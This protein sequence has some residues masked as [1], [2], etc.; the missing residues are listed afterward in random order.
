MGW[1]F[2]CVDCVGCMCGRAL[3]AGIVVWEPTL[4]AGSSATQSDM[5]VRA[6]LTCTDECRRLST[7][8][9]MCDSDM[10]LCH[11]QHIHARLHKT[12]HIPPKPL[13]AHILRIWIASRNPSSTGFAAYA[14]YHL[15]QLSSPASPYDPY[16]RAPCRE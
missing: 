4:T 14:L 10:C 9:W 12:T 3:C 11:S 2:L 1:V 6:E 7:R 15:S 13:S 8:T 16:V 5:I